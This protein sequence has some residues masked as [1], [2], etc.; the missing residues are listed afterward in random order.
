MM[1]GKGRVPVII[2]DRSTMCETLIDILAEARYEVEAA[3][4]NRQAGTSKRGGACAVLAKPLDITM[5]L[6]LADQLV[7]R[8]HPSNN[9]K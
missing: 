5:V 3:P 7:R 9:K 1:M 4:K 2:G 8:D 6:H